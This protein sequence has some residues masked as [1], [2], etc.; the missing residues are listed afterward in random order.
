MLIA[1][2]GCRRR[3]PADDIVAAI[4]QAE[5]MAGCTVDAI[6]APAFKRDEPGLHTAAATLDLPIHFIEQQALL[7]AQP[8][9]VT[10]SG[11][12]QAA[13]GLA[14]VAEAAALAAIPFGRLVLPRITAGCA[15]C[16]IAGS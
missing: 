6:A 2:I 3:C 7:G 5:C 15:T 4:R 8:D 1:G 12:V 11:V 16:A 10:R 13:T 9:C 14:S